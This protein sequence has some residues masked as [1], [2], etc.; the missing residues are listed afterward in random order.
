ML[1]SISSSLRSGI[2]LI[3]TLIIL[4][5][6]RGLHG[7]QEAQPLATALTFIISIA[8]SRFYLK[9]LDSKSIY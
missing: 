6:T 9:I 4:I 2:I 1:A 5:N 8:L 3:P 7:I